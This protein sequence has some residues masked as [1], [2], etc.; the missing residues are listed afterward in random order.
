MHKIYDISD[1]SEIFIYSKSLKETCPQIR[2]EFLKTQIF[3]YFSYKYSNKTCIFSLRNRI[4]PLGFFLAFTVLGLHFPFNSENVTDP[5][6]TTFYR[7]RVNFTT[8]LLIF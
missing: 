3:T 8:A 6:F 1:L 5:I 4:R 7:T 2:P